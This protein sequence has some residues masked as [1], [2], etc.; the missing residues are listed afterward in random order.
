MTT[1]STPQESSLN[2]APPAGQSR[3]SLVRRPASGS[4]IPTRLVPYLALIVVVVFFSITGGSRFLSIDNASF[5]FQQS[6]IIAIPA[7]GEALVIIAGSIDLS[8]GSAVALTGTVGAV[9][10][11]TN[12]PIAGFAAAIVVGLGVG[13][14]N[15]VGFSILRVPSFMVTLGML[16]IARGLTIIVSGSQPINVDPSFGVI[17]RMPGILILFILC[18]AGSTILLNYSTFGRQAVAIGG[19]ERVARLSGVPIRRLKVLLFVFAGLMAAIGGLAL[20][21]RVGAATPTAAT[22]L[23]LQAITAVVLGGTPLTGGIGSMTNTVVGA[24]IISILLNGMVILGVP[25]EAQLVVQGLVLIGA[26]YLSLER[27]KIGIIK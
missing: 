16:S 18:F 23:E 26:V 25:S 19:Q 6:A 22:G 7:F 10:A 2:D 8:I 15:G 9:V 24:F 21:A 11:Q 3:R 1:N 27:V 12:G 5:L 20:T 14:F 17:G 13:L 4:I